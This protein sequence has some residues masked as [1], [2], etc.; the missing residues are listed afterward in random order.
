VMLSGETWKTI[1]ETSGRYQVSSHGRVRNTETG[2]VIAQ[3]EQ[4]SRDGKTYLRCDLFP[5]GSGSK[6]ERKTSRYVHCL[7]ASVFLFESLSLPDGIE[8]HHRDK[9]RHNNHILNLDGLTITDH[10]A[11]HSEAALADSF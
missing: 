4:P 6:K 3:R 10:K 8:V 9:D 1:P 11:E 7:V 5:P 2:R